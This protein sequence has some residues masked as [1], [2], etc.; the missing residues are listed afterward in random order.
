MQRGVKSVD[1]FY[2]KPSKMDYCSPKVNLG[3]DLT[4]NRCASVKA[5]KKL[6]SSPSPRKQQ[7]Y[8]TTMNIATLS[9]PMSSQQLMLR[10]QFLQGSSEEN[11][12]GA[13]TSPP[14]GYQNNVHLQALQ[15]SAYAKMTHRIFS[16]LNYIQQFEN[17]PPKLT[18]EKIPFR[19][20]KEGFD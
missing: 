15:V 14:S 1:H 10:E 11:S 2:R 17:F 16:S 4:F 19:F 5:T 7:N 12:N 18:Q 13:M 3:H 8:Y 20:K 6:I 9:P